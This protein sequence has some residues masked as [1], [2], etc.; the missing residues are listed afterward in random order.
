MSDDDG[1]RWRSAAIR[2]GKP[3][4]LPTDTVYGLCA[5]PYALGARR[6][7]LPAEGPRA[8]QP[9]ALLAAD[10]DMLFECVPEL[11]GRAGTI[12]RALLPGPYTLVLANP[13]RRFRWLCG[14]N[15]ARSASAC[16]SSPAPAR[17]RARAR[18]RGRRHERER[19]GRA[20]PVP[21]RRGAGGDPLEVAA[22]RST[23]ASCPGRPRP[24]STS[25]ARS[26][27]CSA[28]APRP[29][30]RRSRVSSRRWR[31]IGCAA[32]EKERTPCPSRRRPFSSSRPQGSRTSTPTS[33]P[34]SDA[35]STA[36]ATRSS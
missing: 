35:S 3:A 31:S 25:P 28:R 24:C 14:P 10:L 22:V 20:R 16:P 30:P 9:T 18:R 32:Q 17:A 23:R 15:P 21:A 4:I 8:G 27:A 26:R 12:A 5:T 34:C 7:A 29:P 1:R 36:S 2:A 6:A 33:P 19:A 13:A 11:R